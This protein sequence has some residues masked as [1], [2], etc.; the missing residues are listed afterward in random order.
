VS[1]GGDGF[2][3]NG[4]V[5]EAPNPPQH[6]PAD[7]TGQ[8]KPVLTAAQAKRAN[9]TLKGM[10][11]SVLLTLA[12]VLPVIL[13]NPPSES[14]TYKRDVDIA[15]IA[16]EASAAAAFEPVVP[17]M[18]EGW[19]TNFARWN[20]GTADGIDFWEAGLVTADQGFVWL[21]QTA[22]AN[23]TWIAQHTDFALATGK[24]DIDGTDWL[25]LEKS[26]KR[27]LLLENS[28]SSILL[29]SDSGWEDL[30]AAARAVIKG[31]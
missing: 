27:S 1:P 23:P 22:D 31:L 8:A 14:N 12:V 24:H 4:G 7:E 18:P 19:W 3:D 10:V 9:Q 21:R 16:G 13:M 17:E 29:T 28:G 30:E 20:S 26:G 6:A 25:L 5:S 2:G 15:A 11:I